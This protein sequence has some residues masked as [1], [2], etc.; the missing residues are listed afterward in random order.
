MSENLFI[1]L[2]LAGA[3]RGIALCEEDAGAGIDSPGW[4][5]RSRILRAHFWIHP[6]DES[7]GL[8][9]TRGQILAAA[10]RW[11]IPPHALRLVHLSRAGQA[12]A[13]DLAEAVGCPWLCLPATHHVISPR[14]IAPA[15][16]VK[17]YVHPLTPPAGLDLRVVREAF[18]PLMERAADDVQK[19]GLEQDDS[20]LDRYA[21]IR[22]T[23][24]PDTMIVPIE[25]LTDQTWLIQAW[26]QIY[27]DWCGRPLGLSRLELAALR[28][29]CAVGAADHGFRPGPGSPRT[30]VPARAGWDCQTTPAGHV[31][32]KE[33][34]Y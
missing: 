13:F 14:G 33:M 7:T 25:T 18:V 19:D 28:L 27:A 30:V 16:T 17:D 6:A 32:C 5:V 24:E 12:E 23:G 15:I 4:L 31:L 1:A 3:V 8:D 2:D 10:Q 9:R 21:E 20:F 26:S 29:R 34:P 11:R 22:V